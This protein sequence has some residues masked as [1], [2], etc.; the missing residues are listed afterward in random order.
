MRFDRLRCAAGMATEVALMPEAAIPTR[1][2]QPRRSAA[3]NNV[4]VQRVLAA[5]AG[6][7]DIFYLDADE[8]GIRPG[9]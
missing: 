3:A 8:V 7:G 4:A 9:P 1:R 5:S 6:S 2:M